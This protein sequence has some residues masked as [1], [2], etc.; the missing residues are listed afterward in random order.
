M[1]K[2]ESINAGM[3]HLMD[4]SNPRPPDNG[5]PK[6]K[7]LKLRCILENID[8]YI[9]DGKAGIQMEEPPY[10]PFAFEVGYSECRDGLKVISVSKHINKRFF[11]TGIS[12]E[13]V[14]LPM[15]WAKRDQGIL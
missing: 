1:S 12:T 5:W 3:K 7:C 4:Q 15:W 9:P 6:D 11:Q 2:I 14:D 10:F 13:T 8:Y